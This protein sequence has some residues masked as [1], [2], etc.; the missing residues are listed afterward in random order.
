MIDNLI[1]GAGF[2]GCVSARL[3]AEQ[4]EQVQIIEQRSHIGGNCYDEF[5]ENG[6][7]VH[8]YG[9]HLFHTSNKPVWDF[10]S[11]FTQW[12][13]YEHTVL[14]SVDNKLI[15][16][17][18]NFN[19][20]T[21][22]FNH[23]EAQKWIDLL[24]NYY[25]NKQRVPILEL[26]Q[27]QDSKVQELA[28]IIYLKVFAGYTAKQWGVNPKELDPAVTARVPVVMDYDNRYFSDTYQALPKQGYHQLFKNLLDHPNINCQLNTQALKYC[29][30]KK[31]CLEYKKQTPKRF[32]YTGAID[33]LFNYEFGELEYRSLDLQFES[34][35]QAQYQ[36]ATTV[37]YP[38][39]YA[40]TRITEFKH[41]HPVDTP[42][43]HILKEYPQKHIVGRTT[44]YYPM[45][46][47]ESKQAYQRYAEQ[48]KRYKNLILLGRLAEYKYYDMDD[49]VA[50]ILNTLGNKEND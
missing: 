35:N 44:A 4:G 5:D 8:R 9:P 1:I 29:A 23:A 49:V 50:Q 43:T 30:I 31:D 47:P 34:P 7:L 12:Q 42:H 45:S 14:A 26:R 2:A 36:T 21:A 16:I 28:E 38:N 25:S 41:L 18:F 3:L 24:L 11:R 17:P 10:L 32:I 27:H 6:V 48:A 22:L 39:E 33:E 13:P 40:Y 37:N 20:I 46:T 15:P 19:S